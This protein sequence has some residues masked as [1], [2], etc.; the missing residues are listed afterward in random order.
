MT[1]GMGAVELTYFGTGP[2]LGIGLEFS[3]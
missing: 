1:S 3:I 2:P